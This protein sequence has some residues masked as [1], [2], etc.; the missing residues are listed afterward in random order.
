MDFR[1]VLQQKVFDGFKK[2]DEALC[3]WLEKALTLPFV[4]TLGMKI[5][6]KNHEDAL[7]PSGSQMATIESVTWS[8]RE[9]CFYCSCEPEVTVDLS[10]PEFTF[11]DLEEKLRD[12]VAWGWDNFFI[13]DERHGAHKK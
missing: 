8:E 9:A 12:K 7:L 2:S 6:F 5:S 10:N 3:G 11:L 13:D 1:V 4:P